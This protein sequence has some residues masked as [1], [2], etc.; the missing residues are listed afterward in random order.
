MNGRFGLGGVRGL[1]ARNQ[2]GFLLQVAIYDMFCIAIVPLA[3]HAADPG[4]SKGRSAIFACG[5]VKTVKIHR[6]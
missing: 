3:M 6:V 4:I 1:S 5:S 2:L